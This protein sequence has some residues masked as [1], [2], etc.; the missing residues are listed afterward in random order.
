MFVEFAENEGQVVE[1]VEEENSVASAA[2]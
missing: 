2:A 1:I